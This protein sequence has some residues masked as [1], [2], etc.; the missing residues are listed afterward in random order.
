MQLCCD[1]RADLLATDLRRVDV[2]DG[3]AVRRSRPHV[4][5]ER[6]AFGVPVLRLPAAELRGISEHD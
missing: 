1:R 6:R 3:K 5:E 2:I 4:L